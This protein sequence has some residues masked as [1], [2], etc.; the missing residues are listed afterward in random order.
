MRNRA[1]ID[2]SLLRE[3][4]IQIKSRLSAGVKFCAVVKADAYGH[5]GCEVSN[6]LYDIVDCYAVAI[7]EEGVALR[8]AGIDKE[9][10]VLIPVGVE[11]LERA[12]RYSFTLT[13]TSER[14]IKRIYAECRRQNKKVK[15]HIKYNTDMNRQGVDGLESLRRILGSASSRGIEVSGIYTHFARPDNRKA[16]KKAYDKFLLALSLAKSYN[17]KIIGHASSSGGFLQG[18]ELD[19]VRIGILLYGYKPF[20]SDFPVKPIMKVI[21]PVIKRRMLGFGKR[22][23]YGGKRTAIRRGISLI[24]FGYADGLP[25]TEVKGQFNNRCMDITAITSAT[26]DFV[27]VMDDADALAKKYRTISYEILTKVCLRAEK[28]YLR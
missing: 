12:V 15:V 4:A 27:V 3:N 18:V 17:N 5:G 2:L 24:R 22:A 8:L 21:A 23:L 28:I 20:K 19:M 11:D 7:V 16:L 25:R 13:V 14:D 6:A 9:I 10:L 26:G 1:V